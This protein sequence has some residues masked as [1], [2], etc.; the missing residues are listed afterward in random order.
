MTLF[1]SPTTDTTFVS[2]SYQVRLPL[3]EGPLDLLLHLIQKNELDI[4]AISLALVADQFIAHIKAMEEV[5]AD[6]IAD[7]LVVAS[8]LLLIKSRLLLPR[9]AVVAD[10][11]EEDP[12]ELLARRLREYKKFKQAAEQLRQWES[13]GRHA[14]VRVAPPPTMETRLDWEA[15][16][17]DDLIA[18]LQRVLE[19]EEETQPAGTVVTLRKVTVREKIEWIE[20]LLLQGEQVPFHHVV[21]K[22]GGRVEIV[23]SLWAVLEMI[24]RG[25]LRAYQH[26]LF[27]EIYLDAL[28]ASQPF[29]LTEALED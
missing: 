26:E 12:A 22:K 7:F 10:E 1:S 11:D 6:V 27:G 18:A 19:Q 13:A 23:V 20:Q 24:K 2:E 8:K 25:W 16:S 29:D 3:F 15:I 21:G 5:R 9:P 14:Y 17:L 4:T 28:A